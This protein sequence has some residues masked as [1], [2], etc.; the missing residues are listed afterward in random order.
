VLLQLGHRPD[1]QGRYAQDAWL[2]GTIPLVI[3]RLCSYFF[4]VDAALQHRTASDD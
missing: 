2:S 3:E 1:K 4:I